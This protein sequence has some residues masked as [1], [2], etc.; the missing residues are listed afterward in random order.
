MITKYGLIEEKDILAY[1][2]KMIGRLF[3]IIPM[4]EESCNTLD[5]YVDS[6]IRELVGNSKI[7]L[8]DEFVMMV[9]T[10]N[11]LNYKNHSSL[12]SDI[13]KVINIVEKTK[14]KVLK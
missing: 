14:E 13:F 5:D 1:L 11:G 10:L 9:G 2:N 4:Q 6:L 7:F 12:K 8:S 3:K